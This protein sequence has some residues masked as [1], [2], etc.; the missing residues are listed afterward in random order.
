MHGGA[1]TSVKKAELDTGRVGKTAHHA[2]ERIDLT[3]QVAFTKPADRRVARHHPNRI[4]AKRHQ[5]HLR[6]HPGR[7]VGC[8][9]SGVP[10]SDHDDVVMFHVKHSLLSDA[11]ARENFVQ[12]VLDIHPTE[13]RFERPSRLAQ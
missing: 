9:G 3:D 6:T 1:F 10:A 7:R 12:Q 2:I 11:E 13:Q 4:G 8:L 5:S